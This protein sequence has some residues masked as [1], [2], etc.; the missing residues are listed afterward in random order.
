MA[1]LIEAAA[2]K[3]AATTVLVQI[4]TRNNYLVVTISDRAHGASAG[5][6]ELGRHPNSVLALVKRLGATL[7]AS[8]SD[9]AGGTDTTL[10]V[11]LGS[12]IG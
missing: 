9:A 3:A 12:T 7:S 10:S 8:P 5:Q 1:E 11:P 6:L 4:R 2:E